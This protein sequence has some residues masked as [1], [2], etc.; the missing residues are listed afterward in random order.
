MNKKTKKPVRKQSK[1][2]VA[3]GSRLSCRQCGL[4]V[5]VVDDCDCAVPCDVMCCG[6]QMKVSC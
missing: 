1:K 6:E 4:E 3:K 2:A 5:L